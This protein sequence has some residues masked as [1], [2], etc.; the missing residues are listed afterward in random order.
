M[1]TAQ[2]QSR[3]GLLVPTLLIV[4]VP[5]LRAQDSVAPLPAA[6]LRRV[7]EAVDGDR[8]GRL[9][10]LVVTIR[11]PHDVL[12]SFGDRAPAVAFSLRNP[13]TIVVGPYYAPADSGQPAPL[14][15]LQG[16]Y[17][18]RTLTRYICGDSTRSNAI[19][20]TEIRE[21]VITVAAFDSTLTRTTRYSP[22]HADAF[23][24]TQ[25][26][27]DKFVLPYYHWVYGAEY[28]ADLRR[29]SLQQFKSFRR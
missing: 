9:Q 20:A 17:H 28:A 3:L 6:L 18:D 2:L 14:Y 22:A 26:A 25:S 4:A 1:T 15:L 11:E 12:A 8:T 24:F 29:R 10:Y 23:F 7:A 27:V 16:C 19:A 5:G 21:I 13:G